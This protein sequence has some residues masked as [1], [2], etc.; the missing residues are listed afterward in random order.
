MQP[1][2]TKL[3]KNLNSQLQK[4]DLEETNLIIK[5]QKS[6]VCLNCALSKLRC[7]VLD[8]T[9]KDQ[10]EEILFFKVIKPGIV[11]QLIY[12][13]RINNIERKR[14]MGS[15]EK[16]QNHFRCELEKL[17][18]FFN[19]HLEFYGYYR[20]NSTFIDDI[21]FVRGREDIHFHIDNP[22]IYIDPDFSTSMDYMVAEIIANDRIEVFLKTELDALIIKDSNPN[23]GQLGILGNPTLQWTDDKTSLVS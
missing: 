9:F 15:I 2:I 10:D 7:F 13:V 1:L 14:P 21:L 8:Y 4:I 19:S 16:K 22:L 3:N 23:W 12:F 5:A 20:M 6:I 11:S 18:L 17:T